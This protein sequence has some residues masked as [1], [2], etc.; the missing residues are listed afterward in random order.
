[1][2]DPIPNPSNNSIEI[3]YSLIEQGQTTLILYDLLGHEVLRMVDAS[4][5]PGTYTVVADVSALPAGTYV[6]SLRTPTIVKS[7]HLQISR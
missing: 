1:M 3:A 7:N 5:A 6:Y 2:S 4:M